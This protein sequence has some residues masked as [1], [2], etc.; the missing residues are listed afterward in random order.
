MFNSRECLH[1]GMRSPAQQR[2]HAVFVIPSVNLHRECN[3]R[4]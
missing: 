1:V 2:P 3:R 4:L